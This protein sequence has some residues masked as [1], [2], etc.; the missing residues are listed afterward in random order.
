MI[1][2]PSTYV[3]IGDFTSFFD[4]IDHQYLKERL[5]DLLQVDRLN[6]DYYAIFKRITKYDYWDLKDL[7][8]LNNLNPKKRKDKIKINSKARI[9]SQNDYKKYR[10]HIKRHQDNKGIPQGSSISACL[11]NVY[12]LEI[13][14]M[15][16]EFV[17]AR[18]GIYRRYSDDFIII[19]P[20]DTSSID[21]IEAII[22]RFESFK[23]R[24]MLEMQPE[25]TQVYKLQNHS[26]VNIRHLFIPCL[27]Q[28]NKTI[29]FL[30][31]TF[32]GT[33]ITIRYKTTSKYYYRMGHKAKGVAH[34]YYRGNG[35]Q[36][37]DKLYQLYSSNGQY[38][39]GNYFTYLSR[40]QKAFSTHSIMIPGDRIMTKIRLILKRNK[41][42][43]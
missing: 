7:Y 5:C 4:K 27:N 8:R 26:V 13:D 9:L 23:D 16:N 2:H 17:V 33:A 29:N 24:D 12:M 1:Q 41:W 22:K 31:F 28:K 20:M 32:D 6:S 40:I 21:D 34:Q 11:A 38:G 19:L 18:G 14:K 25:K 43:D 42:D 36:G 35:Y 37:S 15:I 10:S 30:G 39:K 3:M